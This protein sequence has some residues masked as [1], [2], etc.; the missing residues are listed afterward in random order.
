MSLMN[1]SIFMLCFCILL[2]SLVSAGTSS[3]TSSSSFS[4]TSGGSFQQVNVQFYQ[5]TLNNLYT[6]EQI[7][8][9]WPML[10]SQD[11][12]KCYG[13]QDFI[14]QV[15]PAGCQPAVVRSDLLEEQN[16]PVFCQLDAIKLNPLIEAKAIDRIIP[17]VS[18]EYPPELAGVGYYPAQA[19][20]RSYDN[21]L[22]SPLI[23]NVGYLV[24]LLKRNPSEKNMPDSVDLDLSA[25]IQ[26]DLGNAWNVGKSQFYLPTLAEEEWQENWQEYSFWSGKGFLRLES[27]DSEKAQISVYKDAGTKISSVVLKKGETSGEIFLPGFYCLAG[28]QLKFEDYSSP[29]T[30]AILQ[31]NSDRVEVRKN[32]QFGKNCYVKNIE[33]YGGGAGKVEVSCSSE[34]AVLS[35][36]SADVNL[37][38]GDIGSYYS[39]GQKIT[40]NPLSDKYLYVVYSGNAPKVVGLGD[41]QR[42]FVVL[43][44]SNEN[45]NVFRASSVKDRISKYIKSLEKRDSGSKLSVSD[46]Q[47]G[48]TDSVSNKNYNV[49]TLVNAEKLNNQGGITF[50]SGVSERDYSEL[51]E[52]P[53]YG[54]KLEEY[55]AEAKESYESISKGYSGEKIDNKQD[56]Y[57][58]VS[59]YA[60]AQL[61]SELGKKETQRALLT[62]LIDKYPSG[63]FR[64]QAEKD[65]E[66]SI[67]LKDT[68]SAYTFK[69]PTTTVR[70]LQIKDIREEDAAVEVAF[71]K[72]GQNLVRKSV[73]IGEYVEEGNN[74]YIKLKDISDNNAT[75]EYRCLRQESNSNTLITRTAS[76]GERDSIRS[77]CGDFILDIEKINLNKMAKVS[78]LPKIDNAESEVNFSVKIGIEK[79]AIQLSTGKTKE[80]IDNLNKSIERWED[81]NSKLGEGVKALKGACFA[82]AA[83]LQAKA[84]LEGFGGKS[85]ARTWAMN[86]RDGSSGWNQICAQAV[87]SGKL[88]I[89]STSKNVNY[90]SVD[91]CLTQNSGEIK[92][93]VSA[94]EGVITAENSRIKALENSAGI[95]S[96]I[97]GEKTV[98]TQAYRQKEFEAFSA[99][100]T[101]TTRVTG[102]DGKSIVV[103]DVL[104]KISDPSYLTTDEMNSV[105]MNM[106]ILQGGANFPA[107][108]RASAERNL[109]STLQ[110]IENKRQLSDPSGGLSGKIGLPITQY[111]NKEAFKGTYN[112]NSLNNQQISALGLQG[113]VAEGTPVEVVNYNGATYV[114]ALDRQTQ[115]Q[116]TPRAFYE[117]DSS[118]GKYTGKVYSSD[119]RKADKTA[120]GLFSRF[121]GF[122][123]LDS[124]SYKN[125]YKNP[126]VRY[127]ETEPY[128]GMPA[129]VPI[130]TSEGWYAATKQTLPT[131]GGIKAFESSGRVTSFWLCNVG[132]D[133]MEQ[134]NTGL[135]DDICQMINL[136]TGQALDLFPGLTS[137][138]ASSLVQKAQRVLME[139][140]EKYSAGVK[141][142]SLSSGTFDV[143]NPATGQLGTR[144]QDFMSPEECYLMFNICDPVI[145]PT[146]RCNLGGSYY[147]DD[148]VQSGIIGSIA[149]CLPNVREGIF[150]PVCLT[151]IHA[152]LDSYLSILKAHRDC[153]Q[154][155]LTSGE[156]IGICDEIY[157]IY[158]CEFF[159]RQLAPITNLIIPKIIEQAYGQGTRGG[160]EYLTVQAAWQNMEKSVQYFTSY[161]A[162]NAVKSFEIKNTEQ[163]GSMVCKAFVSTK[164]PNKLGTLLEPE[165]PSQFYA[166]FSEIPYSDATVPATS[167]YKVFYHIY[168]GNDLGAYYS[169]YLRNPPGTSFYESTGSISVATG[170]INKGEYA[171]ESKDFTAPKGYQELCVRINDEE[172]CGFK[173]VSSDF[174]LNYAN[175]KYLEEQ[176][177]SSVKTESECVSGASS[178]Y[179]MINPNLQEGVQETAF[180]Q[181][182]NR[183]ITRICSSK[184]PGSTSEP[185]RWKDVGYCGDVKI[186]CWIDTSQVKELIKTTGIENSTL[187]E[188]AKMDSENFFNMSYEQKILETESFI[189]SART[190][191]VSLLN[192]SARARELT[193]SDKNLLLS[194]TKIYEFMDEIDLGLARAV[195]NSQKVKLI[196]L[197]AQVWESAARAIYRGFFSKLDERTALASC[198]EKICSVQKE[199]DLLADGGSCPD[200]SPMICVE[201]NS[202]ASE[203]TCEYAE[204]INPR[205][206]EGEEIAEELGK[207][208]FSY[209]VELGD[210][211]RYGKVV[212]VKLPARANYRGAIKFE[213][214]GKRYVF[215]VA[216]AE[217]EN[218]NTVYFSEPSYSADGNVLDPIPEVKRLQ[219]VGNGNTRMTDLDGDGL[220]DILVQFGKLESGDVTIYVRNLFPEF[221]SG[222]SEN[223]DVFVFS[224]IAAMDISE[225]AQENNLNYIGNWDFFKFNG[226]WNYGAVPLGAI[227]EEAS[228]FSREIPERYTRNGVMGSLE[229]G[230]RAIVLTHN[231]RIES[232]SRGMET[233]QTVF[234]ISCRGRHAF[235]ETR[236]GELVD[237]D[238]VLKEVS[239]I[240]SA[241]YTPE[242]YS[243]ED[244]IRETYSGKSLRN[245]VPLSFRVS[246]F[247]PARIYRYTSTGW[248]PKLKDNPDYIGG[249]IQ[250]VKSLG[251][252]G[253]SVRFKDN[254]GEL[255]IF[256]RDVSTNPATMVNDIL[257]SL[258]GEGSLENSN[259]LEFLRGDTNHYSVFQEGEWHHFTVKDGKREDNV[260]VDIESFDKYDYEGGLSKIFYYG[261]IYL[262]SIAKSVSVRTLSNV[263]VYNKTGFE[264]MLKAKLDSEFEIL[265]D[266]ML[267]GIGGKEIKALG[268]EKSTS[269]SVQ[270]WHILL[271][272]KN[273]ITYTYD[274][275]GWH[276]GYS[277]PLNEDESRGI[278]EFLNYIEPNFYV[279]PDMSYEAG[280]EKIKQKVLAERGHLTLKWTAQAKVNIP[281]KSGIY[282]DYNYAGDAEQRWF[283]KKFYNVMVPWKADSSTD[284]NLQWQIAGLGNNHKFVNGKWREWS[285][286]QEDR[287]HEPY[288]MSSSQ[289]N[290]YS[291][292]LAFLLKYI[293]QNYG[294]VKIFGEGGTL[295][296]GYL[297]QDGNT[298]SEVERIRKI[299]EPSYPQTS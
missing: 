235:I 85:L 211:F 233:Y 251:A 49:I 61:A 212:E 184:D 22:G 249:V 263:L 256:E 260:K 5:P 105:E 129:L 187:T 297:R 159:W 134:F 38:I 167:Q 30:S 277:L 117:I 72:V 201:K 83:F 84:L 6:Q 262:P 86:G 151:G 55:F 248:S 175:D 4:Q 206:I 32:S 42:P 110:V 188:I 186:R 135:G 136:Q 238:A 261:V 66:N 108:V 51:K 41:E 56:Y 253:G 229:S 223:S 196:Y 107:D 68:N 181:L 102:A 296:D 143:G 80:M 190:R 185:G 13:R 98:N 215:G 95:T 255:L 244:S 166:W 232:Y 111:Q 10:I 149:L 226:T 146:S 20:L 15:A 193:D 12:T 218:A 44:E 234:T 275:S 280:V 74:V 116:F 39:V 63:T 198:Y 250:L 93:S 35:L 272:N 182:Y 177:S 183:G 28:L 90:A 11:E 194:G 99:F 91:D 208:Y 247:E 157:S 169:V 168:A 216:S 70:L 221:D 290:S 36:D 7:S 89:G 222:I 283:V 144:C 160:G 19:A 54:R 24:V 17:S 127:W 273:P 274:E 87:S 50:V 53:E 209:T 270:I 271:G 147:V 82:T 96:N 133:G 67:V 119:S 88:V 180:P 48:I 285:S 268:S 240:C 1:K 21:L 200:S 46:F 228:G 43:V 125:Q 243:W 265:K 292:G 121:S 264:N 103:G 131:S 176:A 158:L 204:D 79:R 25:V 130:D 40:N 71:R 165:S 104:G 225:Y 106:R 153:L 77:E 3:Q 246:W 299:M 281:G 259:V 220:E 288:G 58:E 112:G 139:A 14:V 192:L 202:E 114:V 124:S 138:R 178:P 45:Q 210:D 231:S 109:Y 293:E 148:V 289:I 47:K 52:N 142:V 224:S 284:Y 287:E 115:T 239:E 266:A 31:V 257:N 34:K 179:T 173:Q 227:T 254:N 2:I 197:K 118:S 282:I 207:S 291:E 65:L 62:E 219:F 170:Y 162:A 171:D 276:M 156:H 128:K 191:A 174:V 172:Q 101:D 57:G 241:S 137:E 37:R 16:V 100:K 92:K 23:N 81:I 76:V 294:A 195:Q 245:N 122:T 120:S 236:L 9:Y 230:L 237:V 97:F 267:Q 26:Y 18:G 213:V 29:E 205:Q 123:K 27:L 8:Q 242:S 286:G 163:V 278:N 94:Y 145:C 33:S 295:Y 113:V 298:A 269:Y 154:A 152:G 189:S 164:Y 150:V 279:S 141:R 203:K 60:A 78:I 199:C 140:A 64:F 258:L 214:N 69:K 155:S 217:G 126:Q 252:A 132:G 161:Y 75:F 73:K 59:L